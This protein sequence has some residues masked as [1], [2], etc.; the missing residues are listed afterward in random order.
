M[1]TFRLNALVVIVGCVFSFSLMA[2]E[3]DYLRDIKPVLKTKCYACHSSLKQK[4]DLRLDAGKFI[5]ESGII[6]K[7]L[8]ARVTHNNPEERMPPKGG[9]LSKVQ[10][11]LLGDW[12]ATGAK[13]P[14]DEVIASKPQDHW[15]FSR[16]NSRW[17]PRLIMPTGL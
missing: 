17:S 6:K 12:I 5:H 10:I 14:A 4:G 2:A 16:C 1:H 15:R 11:D 8:L 3:P 7:E 13:Y 9:P